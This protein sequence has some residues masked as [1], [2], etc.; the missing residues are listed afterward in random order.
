MTSNEPNARELLALKRTLHDALSLA[1]IRAVNWPAIANVVA[2]AF[3]R[4]WRGD[5]LAKFAIEGLDR[6]AD[7]GAVIYTTLRD[8]ST[9]DPPRD[10]TNQPP[11][12]ADVLATMRTQPAS[13]RARHGAIDAVQAAIAQ[14][15][16][17][18]QWQ[19]PA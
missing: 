17:H 3:D 14:A 2:L 19:E 8:L 7:A 12:V 4:G 1:E 6:A 5:E 9:V 11:P 10:S 13:E 16:R 18:G 15:R